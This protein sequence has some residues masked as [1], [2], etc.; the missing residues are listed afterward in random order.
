MAAITQLIPAKVNGGRKRNPTLI[1][2]QIDPQI[3]QSEAKTNT[4]SP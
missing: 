2:N 3:K 4:E 1:A